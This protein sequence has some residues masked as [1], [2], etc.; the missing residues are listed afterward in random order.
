MLFRSYLLYYGLKIYFAPSINDA[1]HWSLGYQLFGQNL[2]Y[3]DA[4]L[5]CLPNDKLVINIRTK[6]IK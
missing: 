2:G 3:R 4:R 1:L 5:L 6:A